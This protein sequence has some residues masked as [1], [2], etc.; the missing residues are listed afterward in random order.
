MKRRQS[1]REV[2]SAAKRFRLSEKR[3]KLRWSKRKRNHVLKLQTYS[4][5]LN[6]QKKRRKAGRFQLVNDTTNL[7]VRKLDKTHSAS[8]LKFPQTK[9]QQKK[10]MLITILRASQ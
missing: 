3:M 7:L 6:S 9:N 10:R 1:G 4:L 2:A 5:L 8:L